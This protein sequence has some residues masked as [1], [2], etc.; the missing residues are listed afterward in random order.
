MPRL[1]APVLGTLLALASAIL[2]GA[3]TPAV[4]RFGAGVG[5]F[6][7]AALIYAGVAVSGLGLAKRSAH[8]EAPL[9]WR[10]APRVAAV[11]IAGAVLAPAAL[12]WGLQRSSGVAASLLV[13]LE[14]VFTVLLGAVVHREHIGK[15]VAL[16]VLVMTAGGALVVLAGER[17]GGTELVGLASVTLATIGWAA[18][19]TLAR[20]LADID[21]GAVV[22]AKGGLGAALSVIV[23]AV[24]GE[25]MP[26][27]ASAVLGL[28]FVG[29]FGWGSSLRLYVLAQR[30]L[31]AGRTASIFAF[32]PFVGAA[33]AML[34]GQPVGGAP[35]W[36]GA[37]LLAFGVVLHL[38][39]HHE[40]EHRHGPLEH[41]HAHRHDD[42]HHE[43]A[44]DPM[45]EGEHS[46][47][48]RHDE[49][50]HAHPHAPDVHHQH[51]H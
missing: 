21:P 2:F 8:Q 40:H 10:H 14:A 50:R 34:L 45:P 27:S 6:A 3:S 12:A 32:A 11:A 43:H 5:T 13:N 24:L 16:A 23:A 30:T 17:H 25:T 22:A 49:V 19:N 37:T 42:G 51:S 36:A 7:T 29:I 31:G 28:L 1:P 18:D 35:T 39:E 9:R 47:W 46:H 4:Q 20:P 26:R 41:E 48:H 44:H 33:V 38:T 15:R